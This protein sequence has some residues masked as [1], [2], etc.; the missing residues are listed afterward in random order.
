MKK[1]SNMKK[2]GIVCDDWKVKIFKRHLDECKYEYKQ[3]DGPT[4]GN[5]TL[6]VLSPTIAEVQPIIRAAYDECEVIKEARSL[7]CQPK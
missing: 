1:I 3:F 6:Q 5:T 7:E 2:I 4:K